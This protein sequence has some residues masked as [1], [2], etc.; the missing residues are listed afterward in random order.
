M[1]FSIRWSVCYILGFDFKTLSVENL[2]TARLSA[3]PPISRRE[4]VVGCEHHAVKS[5][6]QRSPFKAQTGRKSCLRLSTIYTPA[7]PLDRWSVCFPRARIRILDAHFAQPGWRKGVLSLGSERSELRQGKDAHSSWAHP[8]TFGTRTL[9][10]LV[11]HV[12]PG[13][14]T[15]CIFPLCVQPSS[16]ESMCQFSENQIRFSEVDLESSSCIVKNEFDL[17]CQDC[18]NRPLDILMKS[19]LEKGRRCLGHSLHSLHSGRVRCVPKCLILCGL[20]QPVS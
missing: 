3:A 15:A 18:S 20:E 14:N 16:V 17:R 2:S 13:S 12:F 4:L 5:W 6:I 9:R 10:H 8:D 1:R 19:Q 7:A 11:E